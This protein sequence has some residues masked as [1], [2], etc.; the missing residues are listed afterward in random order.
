MTDYITIKEAQNLIINNIKLTEHKIRHAI[1]DGKL[2]T[3]FPWKDKNKRLRATTMEWLTEYVINHRH[4]TRHGMGKTHVWQCWRGMIGRTT[5]TTH[6]NYA[7]YGGRGIKIC[8]DWKQ[9]VNFY[10]DMGDPPTDNHSIDRIDI[11]GNY[12][13]KNCRWATPLEQAK[14]KR[15]L[16]LL[17][18]H[19]EAWN[20]LMSIPGVEACIKNYSDTESKEF[21]L[22][23]DKSLKII[24]T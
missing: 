5:Q 14:N 16:I 3:C 12:E 8:D 23:Y 18:Q 2:K 9:F 24:K 13:P 22:Q 1:A 7:N 10:K 6:I 20:K 17:R 19:K 15:H 21:I 11:D 4:I